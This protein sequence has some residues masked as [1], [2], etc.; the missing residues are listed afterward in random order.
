LVLDAAGLGLFTA[1]GTLEARDLGLPI[2]GAAVIGM[3]T[4]IGGGPVRDLLTGEIPIVLRREIY[5]VASLLGAV[6]VLLLDRADVSRPIIV[7]LSV[8]VVFIIRLM[9]LTRHWS[10]PTPPGLS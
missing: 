8:A 4:G 7:S 1:T 6:I 2:V 10:A 5:A 9:A 3:I